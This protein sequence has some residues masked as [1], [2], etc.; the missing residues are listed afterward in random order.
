MIKL[1]TIR[2]IRMIFTLQHISFGLV[3]HLQT[4]Q[5][6]PNTHRNKYLIDNK[7]KQY[8]HIISVQYSLFRLIKDNK[9][10]KIS[11]N[12]RKKMSGGKQ[13]TWNGINFVQ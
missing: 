13:I 2:A 1:I 5:L 7:T 10:N 3:I 9:L 6:N 12:K 11:Q 8:L 4:P